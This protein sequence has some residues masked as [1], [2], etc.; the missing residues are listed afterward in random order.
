MAVNFTSWRTQSSSS[1]ANETEYSVRLNG[2]QRDNPRGLGT[3]GGGDFSCSGST[4][5]AQDVCIPIRIRHD[6]DIVSPWVG[7][8]VAVDDIH[9]PADLSALENDLTHFP[10]WSVITIAT[11]TCKERRARSSATMDVCNCQ[12]CEVVS[13][14]RNRREWMR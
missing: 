3:A 4:V 9:Q 12:K 8:E 5:G 11:M 6:P 13:L 14:S 1:I 2:S 10:S 7:N